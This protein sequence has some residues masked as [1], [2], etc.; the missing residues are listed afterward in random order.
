VGVRWTT[1]SKASASIPRTTNSGIA[2]PGINF[3]AERRESC[4]H[5]D[6]MSKGNAKRLERCKTIDIREVC[7]PMVFALAKT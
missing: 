2:T 5:T 6:L 7:K 3:K 1:Q 4:S